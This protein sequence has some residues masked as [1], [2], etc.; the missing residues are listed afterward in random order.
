MENKAKL[1]CGVGVNDAS[2]ETQKFKKINGKWK[3][4]WTCPYYRAW[5][6]MLNRCYNKKIHKNRP[7]YI[8]ASVSNEWLNFSEFKKWMELQDWK[9]KS[10]DKDILL[11]G[12]KIYSKDTCVFVSKKLN[13][14]LCDSMR[15]RG[16]FPIGVAWQSREKKFSAQCCNP[17]TKKQEWLGYFSSAEEAYD[18]WLKKKHEHALNYAEIQTDPRLAEALRTRYASPKGIKWLAGEIAKSK[19]E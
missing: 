19:V 12:N 11:F 18:A 1:V 7:S 3:N 6:G 4:I 2:Y 17:E 13:S 8:G 15:S 14:F 10:L 5:R 16:N 9:E